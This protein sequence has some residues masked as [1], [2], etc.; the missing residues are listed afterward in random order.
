MK[1]ETRLQCAC[2][3]T[4]LVVTGAPIASAECCCASCQDAGRRFERLPQARPVL[5]AY[6]A[7]PFV[8]YRKDRVR[9]LSGIDGLKAHRLSKEATTRRV[10]ATCCNRSGRAHV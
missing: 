5:T 3:K 4:T 2:G 6:D 8:L 10:V 1:D 7:T 9:L